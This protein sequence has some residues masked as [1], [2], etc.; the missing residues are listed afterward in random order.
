MQAIWEHAGQSVVLQ[1]THTHTH[2]HIH[3]TQDTGDYRKLGFTKQ[4]AVFQVIP[5]C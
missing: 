2:T 5:R 4:V 3:T 1:A